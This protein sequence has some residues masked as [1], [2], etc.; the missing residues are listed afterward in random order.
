MNTLRRY[1]SHLP[2]VSLDVL[3]SNGD[4]VP[5]LAFL[6]IFSPRGATNPSSCLE[7]R[8]ATVTLTP[9]FVC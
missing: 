9:T 3:P 6:H 2:K 4:L 5:R 8:I 7:A 1:Y